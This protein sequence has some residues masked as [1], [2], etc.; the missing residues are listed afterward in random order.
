MGGK[1]ISRGKRELCLKLEK[2]LIKLHSAIWWKKKRTRNKKGKEISLKVLVGGFGF[3]V[4]CCFCV[5]VLGGFLVVVGVKNKKKNK[6]T[7]LR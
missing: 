4:F 2:I 5:F 7:L 3:G 6:K 1:W